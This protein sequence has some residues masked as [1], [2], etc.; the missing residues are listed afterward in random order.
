[1]TAI[2]EETPRYIKIMESMSSEDMKILF[3]ILSEK[4]PSK[5]KEEDYN[6]ASIGERENEEHNIL[7]QRIES[8]K[9]K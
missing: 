6:N 8:F 5:E 7:I 9:Q 4:L 1:M 3:E 2:S